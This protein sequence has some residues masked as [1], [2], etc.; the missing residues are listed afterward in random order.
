MKR[1]GDLQARLSPEHGQS[2]YQRL[3]ARLR[4]AAFHFCD[5]GL[6]RVNR[7]GER[8]LRHAR[9]GAPFA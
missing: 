4:I 2:S 3:D 5:A 6:T 8:S 7:L 1:P 9:C